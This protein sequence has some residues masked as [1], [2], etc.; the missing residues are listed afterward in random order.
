MKNLFFLTQQKYHL[1]SMVS[2]IHML[3]SDSFLKNDLLIN[4]KLESQNL[5]HL[6]QMH[7]GKYIIFSHNFYDIFQQFRLKNGLFNSSIQFENQTK[8]FLFKF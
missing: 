6:V 2:N 4:V 3:L 8:I 7:T 1:F 5:N